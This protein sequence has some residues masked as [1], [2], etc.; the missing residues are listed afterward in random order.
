MD[1][2][3]QEEETVKRSGKSIGSGLKQLRHYFKEMQRRPSP[4][5]SAVG[6][7][8]T[9]E[10][11]G[12]QNDLLAILD[13]GCN[14]TCHGSQRY[15]RF[16]QATG[17]P[18]VSLDTCA[19]SNMKGIGGNLRVTGKRVLEVCFELTCGTFARGTLP[20]LEL[21]GSQAPLLL[22][23]ETQRQLG[24]QIDIANSNVYSTTLQSN[25]KLVQRDGLLA[26]RWIP[27][28]IGLKCT[29]DDDGNNQFASSAEEPGEVLQHQQQGDSDHSTQVLRNDDDDD[30]DDEDEDE[31]EDDG[32]DDDDDDD[33][34]ELLPLTPEVHLAVDELPKTS[35]TKGKK[36]QLSQTINKDNH[37]WSCL[38]A[39][40]QLSRRPRVL[41]RGCRTFLLEVFAGAAL[42]SMLA[43]DLGLPVSQP[44]DVTYTM[45]PS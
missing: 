20:S 26:T 33:D 19:G 9:Q 24:F 6:F 10:T 32:D 11:C 42:L 27:S 18:D 16:V 4:A 39:S 7:M 34:D 13:T 3:L 44:V 43:T 22:S 35:L 25:L 31:D 41:P 15:E 37:L 23:L 28:Y 1:W 36:R 21:S 2:A 29:I 5:P 17:C 45:E 8:P 38:R 40:K 14:A 12:S 30:D